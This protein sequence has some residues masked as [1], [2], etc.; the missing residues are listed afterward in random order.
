MGETFGV[1]LAMIGNEQAARHFADDLGSLLGVGAEVD[2][3]GDVRARDV[4]LERRDVREVVE[5]GR[6]FD[7]FRRRLAGDVDDDRRSELQQLRKMFGDKGFQTVVVEADGI[8]EARRGF[9]GAR[10][11]VADA[12]PR[13]DRLGDDAAQAAEVGVSLHLA[14][15]AECAGGH[16]DG[17]GQSQTVQG[18]AQLGHDGNPA[19][20]QRQ[21]ICVDRTGAGRRRQQVSPAIRP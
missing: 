20:D 13:G 9:D 2:A 6:H 10:R 14:S 4:Q 18:D 17:I 19:R 15:V 8:Q 16:Q 5:P 3:P 12:G 7:E 11:R 1:S 21:K